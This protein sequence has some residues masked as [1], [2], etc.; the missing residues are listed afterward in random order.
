LHAAQSA[1]DGI[2][3][4]VVAAG[5]HLAQESL[6]V[7]GLQPVGG[8]HQTLGSDGGRDASGRRSRSIGVKVLVHLVGHVVV[9]VAKVDEGGSIAGRYPVMTSTLELVFAFSAGE[10]EEEEEEEEECRWRYQV[11]APVH[12][13]PSTRINWLVA[14]AARIPLMQAWLR[15]KTS[16]WSMP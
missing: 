11:Q 12:E 2:D 14:P 3:A 10:E 7:V 1:L 4:S 15:L 13:L 16:V 5:T 6:L 9:R 8:S